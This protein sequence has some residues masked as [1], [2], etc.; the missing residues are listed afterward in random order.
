MLS[1]HSAH[2]VVN[3]DKPE[4]YAI[5]SNNRQ[6]TNLRR[7]R[8]HGGH[9]FADGLFRADGPRL[10]AMYICRTNS[11][12]ILGSLNEP[13]DITVRDDAQEFSFT[14]HRT[15]SAQGLFRHSHNY[16][17]DGSGGRQAGHAVKWMEHVRDAEQ[18]VAPQLPARVQQRKL[19]RPKIAGRHQCANEGISHSE[20]TYGAARRNQTQRIRLPAGKGFQHIVTAASER[21]IALAY[22]SYGRGSQVPQERDEREQFI[23]GSAAGE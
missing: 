21:R 1:T 13:A 5:F 4:Q 19:I 6:D 15:A 20:S 14:I 17:S 11:T 8:L 18:E 7:T 9:R 3:A 12:Q 2:R 16:F 22:Q 23:A 10:S